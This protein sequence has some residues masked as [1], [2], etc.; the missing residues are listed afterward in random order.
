M[1]IIFEY[2]I[3][4]NL[5]NKFT[6]N[7]K[8]LKETLFLTWKLVNVHIHVQNDILCVKL[9]NLKYKGKKNVYFY[10]LNSKSNGRK[11]IQAKT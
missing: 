2:L 11:P 10:I 1:V 4:N 6:K 8:I 7:F 5:N 3:S 9:R